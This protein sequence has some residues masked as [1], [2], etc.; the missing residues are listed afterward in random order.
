MII[1]N[2]VKIFR[3]K[4]HLLQKEVVTKVGITRQTLGLI[5][6]FA[7]NPSLK[8]CLNICYI[9][10]RTLDEVFWVAQSEG[11]KPNEKNY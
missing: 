9:L 3:L 4:Q 5:E 6:K 2:K 10:G 8:L 7:Y 11:A 1:P